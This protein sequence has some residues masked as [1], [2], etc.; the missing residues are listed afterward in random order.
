MHRVLTGTRVAKQILALTSRLSDPQLAG[1]YRMQEMC[2]ECAQQT[3]RSV[4]HHFQ[5]RHSNSRFELLAYENKK[6]L[7]LSTE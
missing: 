5:K 3:I 2:V 4:R 7:R 6:D 1:E